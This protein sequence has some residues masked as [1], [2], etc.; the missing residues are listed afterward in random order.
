M[1]W[2]TLNSHIVHDSKYY[3]YFQSF[4]KTTKVASIS[5]SPRTRKYRYLCKN[6]GSKSWK[7]LSKKEIAQWGTDTW[8]INI[9]LAIC[10]TLLPNRAVQQ[11]PV[12]ARV[13]LQQHA[14]PQGR[15]ISDLL[16]PRISLQ[17]EVGETT[18]ESHGRYGALR[19]NVLAW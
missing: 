17:Y 9:E 10:A 19:G 18:Q 15:G 12:S 8:S 7:M 13:F 16:E 1:M 5:P 14:R 6:V 4:W 3:Y 11:V 2:V